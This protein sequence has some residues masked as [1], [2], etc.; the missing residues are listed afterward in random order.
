MGKLKSMKWYSSRI[1]LL[2]LLL[3]LVGLCCVLVRSPLLLA[4]GFPSRVMLNSS[5]TSAILQSIAGFG[6][7]QIFGT[8]QW[9]RNFGID[10]AT[11]RFTQFGDDDY[12]ESVHPQ[13]K[14]RSRVITRLDSMDAFW[15]SQFK[16]WQVL[17]LD[18]KTQKLVPGR[19]F[20]FPI[21]GQ[22]VADRFVVGNDANQ[23]LSL[24]LD[25]PKETIQRLDAT[26]SGRSYVVSIPQTRQFYRINAVP[27]PNAAPPAKCVE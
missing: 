22:L 17:D 11:G 27:T 8:R 25:D 26:S 19:R 1:V 12:L 7:S 3:P 5:R 13:E 15:N 16:D 18:P 21:Q 20:E 23:I 2:A 4:P 14:I 24:D 10:L 6:P 9:Q